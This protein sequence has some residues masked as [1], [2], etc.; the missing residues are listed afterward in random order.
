MEGYVRE[1][2]PEWV[3]E[4]TGGRL[5]P[6]GGPI[7]DLHWDSREV[8]P[9]SLFVALPGKRTHGRAFTPEARVR[10]A[11]LVLSDYPGE[12]TVEVEDPYQ[13]LLRL[14]SALRGLF[15]GRVLAVGGSSGKTTTK[16][17]LAQGLA[18]PAPP[19]NQNTAPPLARF[20][21]RLDPKARGAVVELG[22]DRVGEMAELMGLARP[23]LSVLTALGEEHLEAFGSL[24]GAIREELGLLEAE[25][26][27]VSELALPYLPRPYPTYGFREGAFRGEGLELGPEESAFRYRGLRVRVPYPGLGPAYG[28]LAAMAVAEVLGE[29]LE[30]VAERLS[31]LRLPPGRMERKEVGG[32]VFLNDAYNANPLSVRA[33]LRWLAAQPG[34][35]WAVLGE[36][37]ELGGESERLHLEVAE[38][39]ARLGLK[40]LYLG[41]FAKAQAAFGGEAA[42]SLEEA[43]AWL[44]ARVAPG[45]LVYLKAS[46]AVGLE[47]I[48]ELWD[49]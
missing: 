43:L 1:L 39:A 19:G 37:R 13:A 34:R 45:D 47:R 2:S 33:G 23:H 25:E 26:A 10:G 22:V 38:E 5:H 18:L 15:P 11:S 9:G 8:T 16:E 17:A 21:L 28:A 41:T 29:E 42:E 31:A 48:L 27:L 32:V 12:A 3:A 24:E 6:G 49:A 36:M 20:F 46:R 30:G 7:R 44:K 14:G 4:K 40:P 35:K